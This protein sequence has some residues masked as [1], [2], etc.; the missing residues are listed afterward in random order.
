MIRRPPRSTLFPYTTLFRSS[1]KVLRAGKLQTRQKARGVPIGDQTQVAP[2]VQPGNQSGLLK[3]VAHPGRTQQDAPLG[4]RDKPCQSTEETGLPAAG[5]T[6]ERDTLPLPQRQVLSPQYPSPSKGDAQIPYVK[7]RCHRR[8]IALADRCS[9]NS[10]PKP[11][12][13]ANRDSA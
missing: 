10:Q 6:D 13:T 7:Y 8:P 4:R 9:R 1:E 5:R 3:D 11:R 12:R 2:R